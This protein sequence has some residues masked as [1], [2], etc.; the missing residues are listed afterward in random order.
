VILL[1]IGVCDMMEGLYE[2]PRS[3]SALQNATALPSE[4]VLSSHEE[5]AVGSC[6]NVVLNWW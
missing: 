3:K 4:E 2:A 1:L 5:I 6:V